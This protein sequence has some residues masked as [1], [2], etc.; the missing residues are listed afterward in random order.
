VLLVPTSKCQN[1]N[2]KESRACW[3]KLF[4]SKLATHPSL[5]LLLPLP[6]SLSLEQ[7]LDPTQCCQDIFNNL[8]GC[9]QDAVVFAGCLKSQDGGVEKLKAHKNIHVVQMDITSDDEVTAALDYISKNLPPQGDS[10]VTTLSTF[11]YKGQSTNLQTYIV[12][13]YQTLL[14]CKISGSHGD[15][16]E[17]DILLGYSAV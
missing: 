17:N 15:E 4:V 11:L 7:N 12:N 13:Y 5:C 10:K 14:Y 6:I 1:V 2:K 9:F 16:Y 8:C 3:C